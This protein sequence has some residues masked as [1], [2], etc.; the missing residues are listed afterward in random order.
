[1]ISGSY[2]FVIRLEDDAVLPCYKGSTFRGVLGH[3]L[4]KVVCALKRQ[5]CPT[6]L[7]K[8]NCAYAMIFETSCAVDVPDGSRV[9]SAPSPLVLR[10]PMSTRH[11]FKK[12]ETLECTL[13]IFGELNRSLQYFIYAFEQMGRIGIGKIIDGKRSRFVLESVTS[14]FGNLAVYTENTPQVTLPEQLEYI[15]LTSDGDSDESPA[16]G[17]GDGESPAAGSGDAN[18]DSAAAGTLVMEIQTPLR[19]IARQVPVASLPF[20]ML[21]RSII[22]RTTSLLNIYGD[23]EPKMDYAGLIALSE[24]ISISNNSLRW[25]DWKRYSSTQDKKMFMGGLVGKV[26]YQGDFAPFL[27]LLRMAEK[28]H[29]GK[30]TAFGLG[31]VHFF[32]R[33]E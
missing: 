21:L 19:I 11:D 1:M 12:G 4:K 2:R 6:C 30:N 15:T 7:L 16:E 3:A 5:E 26:E 8:G 28:V 27:P 22:R 13:L 25:F 29:I 10:P 14:T 18:G 32:S 31:R 33:Q 9:S 20:P 24:Q 17:S 23:G